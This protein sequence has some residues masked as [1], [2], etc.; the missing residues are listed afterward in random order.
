LV[1]PAGITGASPALSLAM[2]VVA[3]AGTWLAIQVAAIAEVAE[4]M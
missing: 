2:S 1:C 3:G 4:C